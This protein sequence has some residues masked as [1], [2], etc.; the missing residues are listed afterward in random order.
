[1]ITSW[2]YSSLTV[3]EK[4]PYQAQLK[5][6]DKI[7]GPDTDA[8]NRGTDVHSAAE[9]FIIG[10]APT[11]IPELSHFTLELN[12]VRTQYEKGNVEVES[13]WAFNR[14]WE[15]TEWRAKDTWLRL[16]LDVHAKLSPVKGLVV[17]FKTGKL[18]GNEIKHNEQ[19]QLYVGCS[20]LRNPEF[21]NVMCEFWYTDKNDMTQVQ[22]S[23]K[24]A[25]RSIQMFDKRAR[26]MTNAKQFP[27]RPS[28]FSC[29]WCPYRPEETG[30]T[31]YCTKGIGL[32]QQPSKKQW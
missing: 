17:D 25:A 22:Y 23:A 29:K 15:A 16:K 30:G 21:E 27:A 12:A 2:S 19:G 14:N 13:E 26:I 11:L 8:A 28:I 10:E 7:P 24:Q 20:F 31:G 1:M 5:Y 18:F 3:Y 4:C 6:L 9:K 32:I